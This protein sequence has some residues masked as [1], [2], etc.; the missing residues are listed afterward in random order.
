MLDYKGSGMSVME[1]SHRSTW[2]Q[3]IMDE[4]QQLLRDLLSIPDTYSVLFVQGGASTQFY[5]VPANLMNP[6]GKMDYVNTGAWSKKAI[7]E[8]KMMGDVNVV[9]DSSDK[10]F[11]YIP[12][13]DPQKVR[14]DSSYLHIT[15]NNT[16]YGTRFDDPPG[17]EIPL[18]SDM[19]SCILS[20]RINVA[21]YALIY[22]GAQK[23]IGPSGVTT[24]IVKKDLIGK[25]QDIPTMLDYKT[26]EEA[27]SM[28]NTPPTY[29]IYIMKLVFE[30]LVRMG[31]VGAME[32]NNKKKASLVYDAIDSSKL[33]KAHVENEKDRSLMNIPFFSDSDEINKAFLKEAEEMGMV[34]LKG[35]RSVGGMRASIYNAMPLEGCQ[36]LAAFIQDFDNKNS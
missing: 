14:K 15:T 36:R 20:E 16:I 12:E 33:F 27:G 6:S 31:G 32:E 24:V 28:Y 11:S 4:A 7:A 22:A 17:V 25:N 9:A 13:V 18:V 26:H 10:T 35:H 5:M 3:D 23:N 19:S 34:N 8:A 21:D 30:N 2:F 1:L 29:A